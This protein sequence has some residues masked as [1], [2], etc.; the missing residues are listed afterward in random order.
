M[1]W[2]FEPGPHML[3]AEAETNRL[4]G[5]EGHGL[6]RWPPTRRA[7]GELRRAWLSAGG[8]PGA[9]LLVSRLDLALDL[10]W[11]TE[12]WPALRGCLAGLEVEGYTTHHGEGFVAWDRPSGPRTKVYH[13]G[14]EM[15]RMETS[16]QG[17]RG[18]ERML[19]RG[20]KLT[21]IKLSDVEGRGQAL[22]RV[23]LAKVARNLGLAGAR[24]DWKELSLAA[25]SAE[26]GTPGAAL[27]V[28]G[29]LVV[30]RELGREALQEALPARTWHRFKAEAKE[31]F[32]E[33]L[34]RGPAQDLEW[35]VLASLYPWTAAVAEE[36][37]A[38]LAAEEAG[39]LAHLSANSGAHPPE[40]GGPVPTLAEEG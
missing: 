22:A 2:S 36:I 35:K 28:L 3:S 8:E 31:L 6:A 25:L 12:D 21:G 20:A 37:T 16:H 33:S 4:L 23:C 14:Q 34:E 38:A 29:F 15:L 40:T 32:G 24:D 10:A 11:P 39:L 19:G 13:R 26:T 7:L 9:D 18:L 30:E 17:A 1:R 27:R 5:R